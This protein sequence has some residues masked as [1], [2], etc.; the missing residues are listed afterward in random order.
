MERL[1]GRAEKQEADFI[2]CHP[3]HQDLRVPLHVTES[4]ETAGHWVGGISVTALQV[5]SIITRV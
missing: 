3:G 2:R 5:P 1:K 4:L